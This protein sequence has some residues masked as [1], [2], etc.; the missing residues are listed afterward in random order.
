MFLPKDRQNRRIQDASRI[1]RRD[2]LI[3]NKHTAPSSAIEIL[4]RRQA[5]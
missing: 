4:Q 1:G 2:G 3:K 5:L